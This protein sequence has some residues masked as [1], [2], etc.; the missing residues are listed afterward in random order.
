[1]CV[2]LA[3]WPRPHGLLVPDFWSEF[4]TSG[5][6]CNRPT[7]ATACYVHYILVFVVLFS[8]FCIVILHLLCFRL[9]RFTI[10]NA[11]VTGDVSSLPMSN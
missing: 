8:R 7:A 3:I 11:V 4:P 1:M 6:E 5:Y 2:R 9:R 10:M